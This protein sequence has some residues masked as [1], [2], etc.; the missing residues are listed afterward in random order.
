MNHYQFTPPNPFEATNC[1]VYAI[2][3]DRSVIQDPKFKQANP[4]YVDGKPCVYIGMTS[5]DVSE[6]YA[7]HISG[8]NS[9]RIAKQWG[10]GLLTGVVTPRKPTLRR[11]AMK[12]ERS[13]ARQLRASGYGVWQA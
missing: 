5:L 4:G 8:T 7:Q 11:W 10:R 2:D 6:R 12:H 13:T 9:S 3:L 1:V